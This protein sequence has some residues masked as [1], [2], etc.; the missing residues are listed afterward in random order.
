MDRL[1]RSDIV[2][3]DIDIHRVSVNHIGECSCALYLLG[4]GELDF[5]LIH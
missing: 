1:L 4:Y 2:K 3:G 5:T